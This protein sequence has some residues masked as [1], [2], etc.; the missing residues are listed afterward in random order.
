MSVH[1]LLTQY[2]RHDG[3]FDYVDENGDVCNGTFGDDSSYEPSPEVPTADLLVIRP[4][5]LAADSLRARFDRLAERIAEEAEKRGVPVAQIALEHGF[6][7]EDLTELNE[8]IGTRVRGGSR[9]VTP[10]RSTA[11]RK[12]RAQGRR[13][14]PVSSHLAE[15]EI[16]GAQDE[17]ELSLGRRLTDEEMTIIAG[18]VMRRLSGR[19]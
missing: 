9:G 12:P 19:G 10:G 13:R 6:T 2:P 8:G 16:G 4:E 7:E 3:S 5:R 17:A 18:D 11:S 15:L 14:E 1:E